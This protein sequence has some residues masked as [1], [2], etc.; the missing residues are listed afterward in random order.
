MLSGTV[1]AGLGLSAA[2][3]PLA[4]LG[5]TPRRRPL[6]WVVDTVRLRES[7]CSI[8]LRSACYWHEPH[9]REETHMLREKMPERFVSFAQGTDHIHPKR[10]KKKKNYTNTYLV[11]E[12][13]L[14][15]FLSARGAGVTG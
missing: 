1:R 11:A 2:T 10:K 6:C 13:S 14:R 3:V 8:L 15:K 7:S 5:F 12:S 9:T 4:T